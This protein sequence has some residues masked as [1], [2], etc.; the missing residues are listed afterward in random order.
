MRLN[1]L[2]ILA[3]AAVI[4][5]TAWPADAQTRRRAGVE[6]EA[7]PGERYMRSTPRYA[8]V[9][10]RRARITVRRGRSYLDPGTE[11]LP[12]S[13]SDTDYAFPPL[14]Y[15]SKSWDAAGAHRYP[16]PDTYYLPG[17]VR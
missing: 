17:Y 9:G 8:R 2:A 7:Y 6:R 16:L 10:P 4:V 5:L 15:P 11:V 1:P 13:Q 14:W 12:L 3:I